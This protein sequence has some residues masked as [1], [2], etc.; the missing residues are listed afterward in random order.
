MQDGLS[1]ARRSRGRHGRSGTTVSM[2][3][4]TRSATERGT[5][6]SPTPCRSGA[7][8]TIARRGNGSRVSVTLTPGSGRVERRL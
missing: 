3:S 6:P 1:C 8:R 7:P 4:T 2:P 5:G